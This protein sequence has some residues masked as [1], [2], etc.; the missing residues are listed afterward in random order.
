[1]KWVKCA[2][3]PSLDAVFLAMRERA[4]VMACRLSFKMRAMP[5]GWMPNLLSQHICC[6]VSDRSGHCT[7]NRFVK[8][9]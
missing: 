9:A 5:D 2:A 3:S 8:S 7:N 1:M 6:S 4:F